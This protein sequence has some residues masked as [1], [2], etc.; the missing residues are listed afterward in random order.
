VAL[1]T[2]HVGDFHADVQREQQKTNSR[3]QTK[4]SKKPQRTEKR[5]KRKF[6][7]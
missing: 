2:Q 4:E 1:A 6:E 7:I 3:G 5:D